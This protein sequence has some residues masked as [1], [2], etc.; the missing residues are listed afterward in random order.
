MTNINWTHKEVEDPE[1][2]WH[3]E[4]VQFEISNRCF[5]VGVKAHDGWE[6]EYRNFPYPKEVYEDG[7]DILYLESLDERDPYSISIEE[8]N[9]AILRASL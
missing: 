6:Y 4:F 9:L 7:Y 3:H 8:I 1:V 2:S 5:V